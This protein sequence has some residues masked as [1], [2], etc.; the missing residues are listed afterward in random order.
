[1]S[2]P[3]WSVESTIYDMSVRGNEREKDKKLREDWGF[4]SIYIFANIDQEMDFE[5]D[6]KTINIY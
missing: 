4:Y 1:M 2:L 3:K 5:Y 6:I